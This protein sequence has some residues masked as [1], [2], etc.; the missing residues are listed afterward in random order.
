MD[1]SIRVAQQ[2]KLPHQNVGWCSSVTLAIIACYHSVA[3]IL[4]VYLVIN[5]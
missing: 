5:V 2:M 1:D 4:T 3:T